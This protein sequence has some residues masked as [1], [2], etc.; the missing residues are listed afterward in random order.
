MLASDPAQGN[1]NWGC[2]CIGHVKILTYS[3]G[4]VYCKCIVRE[5]MGYMAVCYSDCMGFHE[6]LKINFLGMFDVRSKI[7]THLCL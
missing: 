2:V 7:D 3:R 1:V 4:M 6:L 5:C